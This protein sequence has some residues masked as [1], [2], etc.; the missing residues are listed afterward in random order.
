[1]LSLNLITLGCSKNT[2]DSEHLLGSLKDSYKIM[3]DREQNADVVMINTCGFINDAKEESINTILQFIPGRRSG[4]IKKLIVFGCLSKRYSDELKQ[5]IEEVDHWFG[6]DDYPALLQLLQVSSKQH[7]RNKKRHLITPGHYAYLKIAEGC[8]RACS[9]CIIPSIRGRYRSNSI[10]SLRTESRQ[11]IA[12]G[13]KELIL[14]AQDL[15]YYGKDLSQK[16]ALPALLEELIKIDS[17]HWIR[18]HYLYP[19]MV[20]AKL[21][22]LIVREKVICNYLDI[23]LQHS[24]D[25]MLKMMQRGYDKK[26]LRDTIQLIR[27][28]SPDMT[29]RT[30]F[31]VGHP[32]ETEADFLDLCDFVEEVKFDRLGVFTYSHE[33]GTYSG[34]HYRDDIPERVKQERL[35]VIMEKQEAISLQK[36]KKKIGNIIEVVIDRIENG[37]YISRSENDSPEVDNE[38]LIPSDHKL[39]TGEFYKVQVVKSEAYDLFAKTIE[40]TEQ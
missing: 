10:E 29:L 40:Q 11:L 2:V 17:L 36:N 23:P 18:L 8:N 6:V 32:G 4:A 22:D 1:M 21:L 14:I 3:F 16:E 38:I 26:K 19:D 37:Y 30:T 24:S 34:M 25:K 5:E 9:F 39:N 35:E 12:S 7:K 20:N 31:L 15:S 13:V 33:E 28:K 27:E